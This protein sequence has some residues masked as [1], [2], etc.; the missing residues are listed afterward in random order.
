MF[1]KIAWVM[2]KAFSFSKSLLFCGFFSRSENILQ[3]LYWKISLAKNMISSVFSMVNSIYL[4][5]HMAP[6]MMNLWSQLTC[7]DESNLYY[8]WTLSNSPQ[9]LLA[10]LKGILLASYFYLAVRV[11]LISSDRYD[12]NGPMMGLKFVSE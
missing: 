1:M 6:V 9:H 12:R 10:N 3:I 7:R 4:K 2:E 11:S 8:S 5:Q